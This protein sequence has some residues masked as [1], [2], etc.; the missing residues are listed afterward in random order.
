MAAATRSRDTEKRFDAPSSGTQGV[1]LPLRAREHMQQNRIQSKERPAVRRHHTG[2]L[3]D[4]FIDPFA[5][6]PLA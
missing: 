2:I 3:H 1:Q 5:Q 6:S 4:L